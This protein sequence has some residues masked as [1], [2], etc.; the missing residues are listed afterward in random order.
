VRHYVDT[1][2]A[3]GGTVDAHI[4]P[5]G[6]HAAATGERLLHAE[7]SLDFLAT[8]LGGRARLR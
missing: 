7:L 5:A 6:H 8:H 4:H 3:L 1:L 2:R